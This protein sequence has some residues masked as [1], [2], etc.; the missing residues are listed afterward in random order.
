MRHPGGAGAARPISRGKAGIRC[1]KPETG[2][3]QTQRNGKHDDLH[4]SR[5]RGASPRGQAAALQGNYGA[6]DREE[7]PVA[8]GQEPRGDDGSPP[9]GPA[10]E[11]R[12]GEPH[13]PRE[14]GRVRPPRVEREEGE[15]GARR[16]RRRTPQPRRDRGVGET[17]G[18]VEVNALEVEAAAQ[19]APDTPRDLPAP[20][21]QTEARRGDDDDDGQAAMSGD[22]ALRADLAASGAEL[23]DDEEDDDQPILAP[24]SGAAGQA[25]RTRPASRLAK[26]GA[27]VVAA[28]AEVVGRRSEFVR[29]APRSRGSTLR[30]ARRSR[31]LR[32]GR[33]GPPPAENG[34]P[35]RPS[36]RR[37]S[38]RSTEI[39]RST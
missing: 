18:D 10:E 32:R 15:E 2:A 38:S 17:S 19:P 20:T 13:R 7:P 31:P 1:K 9:R 28:V 16:R 34:A 33:R 22:D 30:R 8:R 5:R 12:Q 36:S 25:G 21:E 24:P 6:R 39:L 37:R 4:G 35:T 26:E 11:R 14:A 3:S 23:F 27:V 29:R